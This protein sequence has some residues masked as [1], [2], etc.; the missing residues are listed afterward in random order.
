MT[1]ATAQTVHLYKLYNRANCTT[2]YESMIYLT[3]TL[4][5]HITSV[6]FKNRSI[7]HSLASQ[8]SI[9]HL[10]IFALL[11]LYSDRVILSSTFVVFESSVW[12][13]EP[14][15]MCALT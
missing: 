6:Q 11:L 3:Y 7:F 14:R 15:Q 12:S 2:Y 9:F 13:R 1:H 10:C 5:S 4:C 8:S